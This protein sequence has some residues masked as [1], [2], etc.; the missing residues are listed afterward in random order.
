MVRVEWNT[1]LYGTARWPRKV[2]TVA[3]FEAA[4]GSKLGATGRRLEIQSDNLSR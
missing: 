2:A 4:D 3:P 1:S